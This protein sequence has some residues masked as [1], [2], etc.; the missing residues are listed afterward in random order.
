MWAKAEV[1]LACTTADWYFN[2]Y[3]GGSFLEAER[4]LFPVNPGLRKPHV[5]V[6]STMS[7]DVEKDTSD[8]PLHTTT[9]TAEYFV[10]LPTTA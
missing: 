9:F 1:M 10:F 7:A 6:I 4:T 2:W 8:W 5:S 3:L